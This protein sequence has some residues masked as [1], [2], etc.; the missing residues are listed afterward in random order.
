MVLGIL[1]LV[2]WVFWSRS[3][4]RLCINLSGNMMSV[5]VFRLCPSVLY[6]SRQSGMCLCMLVQCF[7]F[8]RSNKEARSPPPARHHHQ[9]HRAPTPCVFFSSL[10]A[11]P[12]PTALAEK[13]RIPRERCEYF[14]LAL[15]SNA[16]E[17]ATYTLRVTPGLSAIV[18]STGWASGKAD[19]G[20]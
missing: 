1:S 19:K 10:A 12:S 16:H 8:V 6:V 13:E 17:K 11:F 20:S 2:V 18:T 4:S 9:D 14:A 3:D 5:W 7:C 15:D